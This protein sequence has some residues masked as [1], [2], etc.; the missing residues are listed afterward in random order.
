LH[1]AFSL[2]HLD[3][4]ARQGTVRWMRRATFLETSSIDQAIA[5]FQGA[6]AFILGDNHSMFKIIYRCS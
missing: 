6:I 3:L 1:F 4:V 5:S 2:L